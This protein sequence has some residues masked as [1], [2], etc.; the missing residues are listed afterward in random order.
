MDAAPMRCTQDFNPELAAYGREVPAE[1]WGWSTDKLSIS[2]GI[3]AN[4]VRRRPD[5]VAAAFSPRFQPLGRPTAA[6]RSPIST[7]PTRTP[8]H[9]SLVTRPYGTDAPVSR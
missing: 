3:V 8:Q 2:P 4:P 7:A 6:S 9:S 1:D 5:F